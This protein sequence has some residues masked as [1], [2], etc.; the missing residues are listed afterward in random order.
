MGIKGQNV[1][2]SFSAVTRGVVKQTLG[3]G[4]RGIWLT[5]HG[6]CENSFSELEIH[7]G[8]PRIILKE[9]EGV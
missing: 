9:F 3:G 2:F 7:P 6:G 4:G 8:T 1:C 5:L